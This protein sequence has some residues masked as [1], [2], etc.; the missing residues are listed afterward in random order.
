MAEDSAESVLRKWATDDPE[1][2][3][4]PGHPVGDFLEAHAWTVLERA[5][6]ALRVRAALPERVINLKGVLFGGFTPTY[7]DFFGLFVFHSL[8]APDEPRRWLNT[9]RLD[10]EYF[11]PI[12]GPEIEI[13]GS[14][15]HRRGRSAH[16]E[17]R[18]EDGDTLCAL[19]HL[20]L[21]ESR[22]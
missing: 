7:V 5:P 2:V 13:A 18:F 4:G 22:P 14:L 20:S 1:R 15:L 12:P 16:I 17:V 21:L 10:V 6:G 11:A 9:T 8:R 19:A 3:I